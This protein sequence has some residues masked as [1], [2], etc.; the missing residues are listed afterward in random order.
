VEGLD[1]DLALRRRPF[2][3]GAA[4]GAVGDMAGGNRSCALSTPVSLEL[5]SRWN[6]LIAAVVL[7]SNSPSNRPLYSVVQARSNWM[8]MRSASGSPESRGALGG[9]ARFA[10]AADLTFGAGLSLWAAAGSVAITSTR[11]A[12]TMRMELP[13]RRTNEWKSSACR[14]NVGTPFGLARPLPGA[15]VR[16]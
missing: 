12:A 3:A 11:T 8:A 1:L 16:G 6:C 4:G 14:A 15:A 10:L 2:G 13:A 5:R 9:G 7:S